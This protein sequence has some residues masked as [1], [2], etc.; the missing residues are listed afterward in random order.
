MLSRFDA[1]GAETG[2][3]Q[4]HRDARS[5][6]ERA[7]E[8]PLAEAIQEIKVVK[9]AVDRLKDELETQRILTRAT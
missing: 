8:S 4:L 2:A 6:A 9:D 7:R 1:H 3:E 5:D